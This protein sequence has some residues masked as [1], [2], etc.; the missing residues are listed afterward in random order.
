M[1]LALAPRCTPPGERERLSAQQHWPLKSRGAVG[2]ALLIDPSQGSSTHRGLAFHC[3]SPFGTF[4]NDLGMD[5]CDACGAG[6]YSNTLGAK[7]CKVGEA[8]TTYLPT[9]AEAGPPA[10]PAML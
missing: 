9:S 8:P 10:A 1:L 3:R 5:D 7:W 6:L 4:N 2:I